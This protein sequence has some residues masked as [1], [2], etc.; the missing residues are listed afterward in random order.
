MTIFKGQIPAFLL[1]LQCFREGPRPRAYGKIKRKGAEGD[2]HEI[3]RD[4]DHIAEERGR[5][6]HGPCSHCS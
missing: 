3:K 2:L 6:G 4:L 5:N 1:I